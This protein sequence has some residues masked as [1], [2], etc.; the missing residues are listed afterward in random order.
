MYYLAFVRVYYHELSDKI[1][2]FESNFMEFD[3]KCDFVMPQEVWYSIKGGKRF[4]Q[5]HS[6]NASMKMDRYMFVCEFYA[7]I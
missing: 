2:N 3:S 7:C 5:C 6:C 1:A 4:M